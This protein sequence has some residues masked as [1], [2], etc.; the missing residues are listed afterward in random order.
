MP[1]GAAAHG[2]RDNGETTDPDHELMR[3]ADADNTAALRRIIDQHG[4]PGHTL[5]GEQAAN[6]A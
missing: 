5:V 2:I 4:W 3:T 1:F 6:A